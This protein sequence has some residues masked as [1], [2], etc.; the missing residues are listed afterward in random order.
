MLHRNISR[1]LHQPESITMSAK[2]TVPSFEDL[3]APA[4]AINKIALG[5]AEKLVDMNITIMR[6]QAD[7]ALAG[8]REAIA[9]KNADEAKD[10][11]TS[12]GEAA[13]AVVEGYVADAKT[14]SKLNQDVAEEVRKVV[15]DSI[16]KVAKQA[17]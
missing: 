11:L 17:A 5:Y 7:V 4:I 14:V 6:K 16:S 3:V 9:V 8:W 12:Q 10:Y 2:Q 13:R 15:E 1:F